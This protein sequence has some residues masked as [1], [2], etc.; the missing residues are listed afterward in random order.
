MRTLALCLALSLPTAARPCDVALV[1]AIDVSGSIDAGEY[2]TQANGT[3]NALLD[4]A[5]TDVLLEGQVAVTVLHW[6]GQGQQAVVLPWVQMRAPADIV[7]AANLI[8]SAPRAFSGSDTAVGEAIDAALSLFA[9]APRCAR[10]IIDIS[11]D[12]PENSGNTVRAARSRASAAGVA[13][14][15][16]A[17]EDLG[18]STAITRFYENWVIT[19]GGFVI[20]S[21]GVSAYPQAI[22]AKL[23]RELEKPAS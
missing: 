16:I 13:I 21:R 2:R 6:S 20:T 12:G 5:V 18:Q 1:L 23:L 8:R 4:P 14:N 15:A 22:R 3:A 17:I 19:R 11:G 7:H 9:N 10:N